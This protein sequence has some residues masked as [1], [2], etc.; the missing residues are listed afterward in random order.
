MSALAVAMRERVAVRANYVKL[1][2]CRFNLKKIADPA[3]KGV[4]GPEGLRK[5]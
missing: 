5:V 4:F 3:M 2:G 1:G